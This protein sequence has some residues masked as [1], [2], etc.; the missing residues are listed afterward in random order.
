V[1]Y[2]RS[3]APSLPFFGRLS[4]LALD[5]IEKKPLYHFYPGSRIL[6]AG[7]FGCNL[8]CPFC[9][10]YRISQEFRGRAAEASAAEAAGTAEEV[11]PEKLV[12][13]GRE[14]DSVGLA[15]TYSEPLVHFEYIAETAARARSAGLKNVLVSNGYVSRQAAREILEVIDA[16][17]IDVKSFSGDFYRRE[18]R[19]SL[20]PVLDFLE[21]AAA[22]I[23]LEVTTL[24]IPGK[25]DSAREM[26]ELSS[27]IAALDSDIPLHLS[28]YRPCYK[29][30]VPASTYENLA[31]LVQTAREK[32]RYV[33]PGN[34]TVEANTLCPDCGSLLIHR[35]G[36]TVE[37]SGFE[38]GK[39][40]ACGHKVPVVG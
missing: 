24:I 39:C 34:V 21:C 26:K 28:C 10:N 11:S 1:R 31:P 36:Y 14:A 17:N 4:A 20:A 32:L 15:Y 35:R 30:D 12:S 19:G 7:F 3:G 9:Q 38:N 40:R 6:S 18:L 23:H 33:Y 27:H 37:R 13:L 22:K 8:A 16:A 2:N 5:P 29:Y 25:N